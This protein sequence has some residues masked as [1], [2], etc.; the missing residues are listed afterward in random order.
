MFSEMEL[1]LFKDETKHLK[2]TFPMQM[3]QRSEGYTYHK[4]ENFQQM[5]SIRC[6]TIEL[7]QINHNANSYSLGFCSMLYIKI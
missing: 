5:L 1:N 6:N 2:G 4:F 3:I 7:L